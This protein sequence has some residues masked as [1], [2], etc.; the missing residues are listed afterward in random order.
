MAE[1][2]PWSALSWTLGAVIAAAAAAAAG[3]ALLNKRDSRSAL[4]W[5]AVCLMF[6]IA[7]PSLYYVFGI[8]RI[9][10]RAKRLHADDPETVTHREG[11]GAPEK[12]SASAQ[13][14]DD[15]CGDEPGTETILR[16]S[17]IV[18]GLPRC[19]G[20]HVVPLYDGDEAYPAM[21]AAI[22][23]ATES[24][25][26]ASYIF[27]PGKVADRIVGAL[28][29]AAGRGVRVRVLVDG[30][31]EFY[32]RPRITR[33]LAAAGIRSARFLPPRLFPPQLGINLRNHRK[34][35]VADGRI[36]LTGGMNIRDC[37]LRDHEDPHADLHCRVAGP[38]VAQLEEVFRDDWAFV[39]GERLPTSSVPSAEP[40]GVAMARAI[41]D[42]PNED[43][44]KLA[45]ILIG[46]V[47]GAEERVWITTP[48]FLPPRELIGA[49]KSAALR[50][51][52]VSV[53]LPAKNNLPLM[54]WA[55]ANTLWELLH[56][57]VKVFY[58]PPP[59]AH[60]KLLILDHDY[61]HLGSA[62]LDPRSLRLNFELSLELV[63]RQLVTQMGSHFEQ[64]RSRSAR[65]SVEDLE[66]RPIW[67]RLRDAA[68]W[69]FSPYL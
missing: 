21:L 47:G 67:M 31:G 39:T 33:R 57:G 22:D 28:E 5:I 20:N 15:R 69:L 1:L 68:A 27:D 19:H 29:R 41:V 43:L 9:R 53:I 44:D 42:G 16:A 13:K 66:A 46:A 14:D 11:V 2:L 48:Y 65:I 12:I 40:D 35:L 26:L 63:D 23:G 30:V 49:M 55:A 54:H 34:I 59:F 45:T 37:H 32:G 61:L 6:P 8:N 52:D 24:V 3:H 38:V 18:T 51:V 64:L 17:D 58:Q 4:G 36:A 60:T 25:Y 10:T 62:N 50:G 56:W 7:G